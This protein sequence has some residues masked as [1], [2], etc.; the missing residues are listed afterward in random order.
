MLRRA[1]LK[2]RIAKE[3]SENGGDQANPEGGEPSVHESVKE[4]HNA[5]SSPMDNKVE[6]LIVGDIKEI[7]CMEA[8]Y[9]HHEEEKDILSYKAVADPDVM[10]MHQAMRQP[11]KDKFIEAMR[12]EVSEQSA[13]IIF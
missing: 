1:A 6:S 5:G 11:D 13:N 8:L 9:P 10:Y 2:D 4:T 7:F 12:K 3:A